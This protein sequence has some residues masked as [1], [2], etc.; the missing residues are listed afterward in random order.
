MSTKQTVAKYVRPDAPLDAE[1]FT[2]GIRRLNWVTIA[3]GVLLLGV[4]AVVW[5]A[6]QWAGLMYAIIA[7]SQLLIA[8]ILPVRLRRRDDA[9]RAGNVVVQ[10]SWG[11]LSIAIATV[12]IVPSEF[13]AVPLTWMGLAVA[14]GVLWAFIGVYGIYLSSQG[15]GARLTV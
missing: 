13:F 12:A 7:V 1:E 3:L 10:H 2:A 11:Q 15:V 5:S 14:S 8:G 4:A 6:N 9:T